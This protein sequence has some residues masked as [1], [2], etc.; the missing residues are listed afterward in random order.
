MI[1]TYLY[2]GKTYEEEAALRNAIFERD[3]VVFGPEPKERK[4]EFWRSFDVVYS[5]R[6]EPEP[7]LKELKEIRLKELD[8]AF[9]QWRNDG[10]VLFS[11]LGFT[12]DADQRAMI[13]L[14]GLV[15]LGTPAIFMDADNR[16]HELTADQVGVLH[17]EI[18]ESGNKAY[19]TKWSFRTAIESA[20]D[21]AELKAIR[22]KFAPVSFAGGK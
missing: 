10:A 21:A 6:A 9:Y 2:N 20:S 17:K 4:A 19:Q 12:A 13:D 1:K 15:A 16:P 5:E 11:S 14:S 18:I 22:I 7:T 8:R 3:R